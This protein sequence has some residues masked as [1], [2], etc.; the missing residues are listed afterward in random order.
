[1]LHPLTNREALSNGYTDE[2]YEFAP[3]PTCTR[4]HPNCRSKYLFC[5]IRKNGEAQCMSKIRF[6]GKCSG[7]EG[8]E[9]CFVGECIAG[10]CAKG[11]K[12]PPKLKKSDDNDWYM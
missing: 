12:P 9:I 6:G 5:H 4:N 11:H 2:M 7:F 10:V 1:M 8:T 3:R